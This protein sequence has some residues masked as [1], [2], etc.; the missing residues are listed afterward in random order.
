MLRSR[1]VRLVLALMLAAPG[2]L[3]VAIA[4]WSTWVAYV[5]ANIFDMVHLKDLNWVSASEIAGEAIVGF[6]LIYF[7]L[8][9]KRWFPTPTWTDSPNWPGKRASER[10][11]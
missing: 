5:F 11:G 6:A 9:L 4:A 10:T 2:L 3:L 8:S 7:G 1:A